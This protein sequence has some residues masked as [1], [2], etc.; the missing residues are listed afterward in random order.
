ML[1]KDNAFLAFYNR[2]RVNKFLVNMKVEY[3]SHFVTHAVKSGL[4]PAEQVSV[5]GSP[6]FA[7]VFSHCLTLPYDTVKEM[8]FKSY[9]AYKNEEFRRMMPP[10]PADRLKV[11]S[12]NLPNGYSPLR[13]VVLS[14]AADSTEEIVLFEKNLDEGD[15]IPVDPRAEANLL[16]KYAD[17]LVERQDELEAEANGSI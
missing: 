13:M 14:R 7:E 4:Y 3:R 11:I 16:R 1:L 8:F 2:Y 10:N 9:L 5:G 17:L 15:F 6:S 12:A